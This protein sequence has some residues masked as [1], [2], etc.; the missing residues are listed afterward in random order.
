M[1]VGGATLALGGEIGDR[2]SCH[3]LLETGVDRL[4]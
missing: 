3:C 1:C 2:L 4:Q